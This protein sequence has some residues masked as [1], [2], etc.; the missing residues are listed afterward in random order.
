MALSALLTPMN[1]TLGIL[2]VSIFFFMQ[3]KVRSDLVA[4]CSL[5]ALLLTGILDPNE[6]LEGFSNPVIIMMIGLFVVG[7]GI[8]RT[9]LAKMISSKILGLAGNNENL[10]FILVMVVTACVGAFVSNTGTVAVMM[11][12]IMSL[13]ASA[14]INARRYLMPLAFASSMG[15]FT[16]I[17]TPPNMVINE[18]IVKHGYKA[19]SFFSFAPIGFLS[20][21]VGMVVL[22][23]LSKLLDDKNDAS[24]NS[25]K[26]SKS[27]DDLA[28]EYN[29][30]QQSFS[31][32]VLN[33]SDIIGKTLAQ[34]GMTK[35]Y[36]VSVAKLVVPVKGRFSKRVVEEVAGPNSL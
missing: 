31:V 20:L 7:A 24:S 9:G 34:I 12:I 27:L 22:F 4:I 23:F 18:E 26:K 3:G 25:N 28:K 30:M 19:L 33:Q 10:L 29:L 11:P 6:A 17:S 21:A 1:I 13:A 36:N 14:N 35:N 8:F 15:L 32:T 5:V 2:A 16:L